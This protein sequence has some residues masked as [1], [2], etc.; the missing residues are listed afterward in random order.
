MAPMSDVAVATK[1]TPPASRWYSHGH[2]RLA[3]YRAATALAAALPRAARLTLA[4]HVGVRASVWFPVERARVRGNVSRVRPGLSEAAREAVVDDVFRHFAMC[5]ADLV[6]SNRGRR[7]ERLAP[8]VEG[9]AYIRAALGGGR[10]LVVVTAHLGNW[11][12][13]G[14]LVAARLGRP[15][16][17]VVA[18]EVDPGLERFLRSADGPV[19]FV[20][21]GKPEAMVSLVRALRRG[22]VVALQG[23]RSLG[24]RGDSVVE[25]FGA[26]AAFP[27]GP[28][29]L[30]RAA[31]VPVVPAFCVLG[32]D[33]RYTVV[34]APA[35][36]VT[37]GAEEAAVARWVDTLER[38]VRRTPEQ[39]FNFYDVWSSVP[40]S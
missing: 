22:D 18:P 10:G 30:A 19:R 16:H 32:P 6:G 33:R 25:F 28:F 38:M 39:W 1:A 7:P 29:V 9:E 15:T 2:N 24:T 34:V 14:R 11:E 27:R 36:E 37:A 31:G 3:L 21:L 26:P 13:G 8:R 40:A 20:R 4:G 5:F 12:L 17:V 35:L 23:D